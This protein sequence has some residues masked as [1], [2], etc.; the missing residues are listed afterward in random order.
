[1]KNETDKNEAKDDV[2]YLVLM[3]REM[4]GWF[5]GYL[6]REFLAKSSLC[7]ALNTKGENDMFQ[8]LFIVFK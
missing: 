8:P 1:M 4:D 5:S 6:L 3:I 7:T 2:V